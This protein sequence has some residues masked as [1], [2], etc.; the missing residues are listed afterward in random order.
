MRT[1]RNLTKSEDHHGIA[2]ETIP[3]PQANSILNDN[4]HHHLAE[5]EEKYPSD[6]YHKR[7]MNERNKTCFTTYYKPELDSFFHSPPIFIHKLSKQECNVLRSAMKN[8]MLNGVKS[9]ER[10]SDLNDL[11]NE[12]TDKIGKDKKN[13]FFRFS[14]CSPKDSLVREES[15]IIGA[16]DVRTWLMAAC[17]SQRSFL[18]FDDEESLVFSEYNHKC[19]SRYEWR[20]FV[21]KGKITAM[22][23][24]NCYKYVGADAWDLIS[25]ALAI[26]NFHNQIKPMF[27]VESYVLDVLALPTESK[28]KWDVKLIELNPFGINLSSGSGCFSWLTDKD[29]L[30]SSDEI[31]V[32]I[33]RNE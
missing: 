9:L 1:V 13:L 29:A 6:A 31:T 25:L 19:E 3:I 23:Q 14:S 8:G 21:N 32:R 15:S 2:V 27:S 33:V 16:S 20:V 28:E 10:D 5:W 7:Y 22:S 30:Y 17:Q 12:I 11:I 26:V 24:Y 4:N 18:S